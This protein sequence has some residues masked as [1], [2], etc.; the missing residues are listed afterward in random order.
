MDNKYKAYLRLKEIEDAIKNIRRDG[1][2]VGYRNGKLYVE[3]T[4][5]CH[6]TLDYKDK[7]NSATLELGTSEDN[8][9]MIDGES[10]YFIK[11]RPLHQLPLL[12]WGMRSST[13]KEK[14]VEC[15]IEPEDYGKIRAVAL[16]EG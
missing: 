1:L 10:H 9:P 14:W 3:N 16:E 6:Q 12:G 4:T 7:N 13:D 8:N 2:A 15:I 5:A 11:M